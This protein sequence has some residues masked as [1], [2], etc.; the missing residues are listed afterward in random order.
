MD[1][2]VLS[3]FE[4]K[5]ETLPLYLALE[6]KLRALCPSL[7]VRVQ[8]TQISF[9]APCLFA[10]VWLPRRKA[11]RERGLLGVSFGLNRRAS[12]LRIVQAVEPYPGR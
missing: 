3:F 10:M 11:E 5:P 2:D 4:K 8:K 6:E 7:T 12:S 9:F 1:A